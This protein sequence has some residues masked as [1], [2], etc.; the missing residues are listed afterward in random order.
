MRG[1]IRMTILFLGFLGC[2]DATLSVKFAPPTVTILTPETGYTEYN[3]NPWEFRGLATHSS[4]SLDGSLV[5]WSSNI[6]GQIHEGTV[7]DEGITNFSYT[8]SGG[9]HDI[10]LR[11]VDANGESATDAVSVTVL[12]NL[13]PVIERID[14]TPQNPTYLDTLIASAQGLSDPEGEP[15]VV[16]WAWEKNEVVLP[17]ATSETLTP[18]NFEIGDQLVAIATPND[19]IA[20]G[21][22]VRSDPIVISDIPYELSDDE[23]SLRG[24]CV[25]NV[26]AEQ[27]VLSNDISPNNT[28]MEATILTEPQHGTVALQS[29]GSFQ[30]TP[31]GVHD[32]SFS[33]TVGGVEANVILTG[34]T[35]AIIVDTTTID[36]NEDGLC[37]LRE[38]IHAANLDTAVDGCSSGAGSDII[39]FGMSESTHNIELETNDDDDNLVGDLDVTSAIEILGCGIDETEITGG[40]ST[41]LIQVHDG[42]E[43]YL[44]DVQL[45]E[46]GSATSSGGALWNDG[47]TELYGVSFVDNNTQGDSGL[48]GSNAGGGGGGAAAMGGAIFNEE[49]G[50]LKIYDGFESSRFSGNSVQG[51][52]GANGKSN[53]GSFSGVGGSGGGPYGGM[54]GGS[55]SAGDG[56]FA[57]GGGGGAGKS[58]GNGHGGD[59]GFGGGGGGGGA[60]TSGGLGGNAGQGGFGGG[61]G[62]REGCSAAA[63]G[64]GGAGFGGA[65]FNH[66]GQV[67]ISNVLFES[68]QAFGGLNGS[69][70]FGCGTT[71]NSGGGYGGALFNYQGQIIC[72]N[73]SYQDN[74][75][76]TDGSDEY[77]Y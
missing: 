19:G 29:D 27:G 49:N 45:R 43:L 30:Y 7:D 47:I 64:G 28:P 42:G 36:H 53:G 68:N 71:A 4:G 1:T 15:V 14:I 50:I 63:G 54:G 76:D 32:D 69:N 34:P 61:D 46:G 20:N 17:S 44:Y 16:T 3:T 11:V 59:G 37:S 35:S 21:Q 48:Q 8:L 67:E 23:Y 18:D 66:F 31:S 77:D 74:L 56:G 72:T 73:C 75:A 39:I 33:Y 51:G 9:E 24:M 60:K 2:S 22:P 13:A 70:P 52:D 62:G 58:S 57:S 65:I 41:R 6:D 38:A 5:S 25:I 12:E 40:L 10:T 26:S 55:A